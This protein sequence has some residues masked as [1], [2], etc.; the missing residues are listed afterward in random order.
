[1]P[2]D[3]I[4]AAILGMLLYIFVPQFFGYAAIA[5]VLWLGFP[6]TR[7]VWQTTRNLREIPDAEDEEGEDKA[8]DEKDD[9]KAQDEQDE[10]K[11]EDDKEEENAREEGL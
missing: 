1:M 11:A 3:T 2:H 7:V 10:D 5:L 8:G 9:D 6:V 4:F